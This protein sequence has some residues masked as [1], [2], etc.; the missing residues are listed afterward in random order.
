MS[1]AQPLLSAA[2]RQL[3]RSASG[4]V[5]K[6]A[7][8]FQVFRVDG[9]SWTK[10]LPA[11]ER[12]SSENFTVGGRDWKIDYYPNGSGSCSGH[13]SLHLRLDEYERQR[14]GAQYRFSL[15]GP[16]G[17]AAY[18]LPAA[19]GVFTCPGAGGG[20]YYT[21]A[22]DEPEEELVVGCGYAEFIATDELEVRRETL[23]K[24]DCLAI[25]CDVA[26][27]EVEALSLGRKFRQRAP[28]LNLNYS[29]DDEDSGDDQ[30]A[31]RRSRSRRQPDDR[32]YIRQCLAEQRHRA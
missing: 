22:D 17:A 5:V 8:G 18:E 1:A 20:E 32:E 24:D 21:T 16:S 29:D 13:I 26:V 23:L 12:I 31:S 10:A 9:Y 11:G 27:V 30:A 6:P 2:V 3:S 25:R 28:K 15:L 4:V 19:T 14:V 7:R